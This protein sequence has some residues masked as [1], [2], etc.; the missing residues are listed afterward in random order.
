MKDFYKTR[1]FDKDD[2]KL[3]LAVYN[4]CYA[5]KIANELSNHKLDINSIKPSINFISWVHS[6]EDLLD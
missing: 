2:D 5:S 6:P 4:D 1:Q 3:L